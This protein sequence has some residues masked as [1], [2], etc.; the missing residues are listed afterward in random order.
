MAGITD[1]DVNVQERGKLARPA[2]A[3]TMS[4]P[5]SVVS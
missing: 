5:K 3:T 4:G 2:G 1:R